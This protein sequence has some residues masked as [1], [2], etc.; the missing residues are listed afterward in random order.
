MPINAHPDFLEAEKEYLASQTKEQKILALKKMISHVPSHKG[1]ENLRAQL[2]T[3]YKKLKEKEIKKKKAGK[4][5]KTGIRKEE[6]QAVII[7]MTNTGKSSLLSILTNAYPK[8]ANYKFTTQN[9]IIGIMKYAGVNMQIIEIPAFESEHYDKGLANS[10]DT[11][12]ILI[13]D[14]NQIKE[15]EENIKNARGK[16]IIVFNR[17]NLDNEEIRKILAT[18]SSKRY[19]FVV[20]STKTKQNIEL[21][22]D[23]IFQSFNK[24][25]IY[26]KEPGKEIN[27]EKDKPV[28]LEK[29]SN[30]KDVAEKILHG[31]SNQIRETKIW[32]PSSKFSGQV[33]GLKHIL[34]DLDIVEFKTR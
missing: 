18:L 30:V 25:R 17:Q 1:A 29:D 32:G 31:F 34:K 2:K 21:L 23:K 20:I 4:S 28:I 7:G 33:V 6:M 9:P 19:N 27:R 8:I 24:I 11:I 5:S 14:L 15:I 16:K 13:T 3:R 22:K 12:L 26:T 10:A